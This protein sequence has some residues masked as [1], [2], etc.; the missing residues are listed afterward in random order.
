VE[1]RTPAGDVPDALLDAAEGA[2]VVVVGRRARSASQSLLVASTSMAVAGRSRVPVV[3]VPETWIQPSL[4]SAP[5]VVGVSSSLDP[6]RP[7]RAGPGGH[8][9]LAFAFAR[10][11]RLRVPLIV[12]SAWHV[13]PLYGWSPDDIAGCR[14][15]FSEALD[16]RLE[17]WKA[18]HPHVEVVA[19]SVAEPPDQA[20]LEAGLVAQLLVVGRRHRSSRGLSRRSTARSVLHLANRPVAVVPDTPF[21][22]GHDEG[23]TARTADPPDL[24]ALS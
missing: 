6:A 21:G 7:R 22:N 15:Q 5:V 2:A 19:R 14:R 24:A 16:R 18:R 23:S 9:V 11:A 12:V 4:S 17:P 8:R 20:L 3:V 13:P 1:F 10:A